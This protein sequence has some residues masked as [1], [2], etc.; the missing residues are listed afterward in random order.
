MVALF[1]AEYFLQTAAYSQVK[2]SPPFIHRRD[3]YD[4]QLLAAGYPYGR[5]NISIKSLGQSLEQ[6]ISNHYLL[7]AD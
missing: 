3:Q 2:L 1:H 7:P 5:V 4:G 6:E